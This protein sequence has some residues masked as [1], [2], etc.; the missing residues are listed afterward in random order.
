MLGPLAFKAHHVATGKRV[1]CYPSVKD[2]MAGCGKFNV[3]EDRVS[4][5]GTFIHVLKLFI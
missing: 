5:D 2:E 4:I 1:T 3:V